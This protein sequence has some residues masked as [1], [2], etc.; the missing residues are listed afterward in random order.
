MIS[1]T[2]CQTR[3]SNW[4]WSSLKVIVPVLIL[5]GP[6]GKM[7]V[8]PYN[9]NWCGSTV[10]Q[11]CSQQGFRLQNSW[12]MNALHLT[13]VGQWGPFTMGIG[14][15]HP[16]TTWNRAY[17]YIEVPLTSLKTELLR[18]E[19][20]SQIPWSIFRIRVGHLSDWSYRYIIQVFLQ[21]YFLKRAKP[22]GKTRPKDRWIQG[23]KPVKLQNRHL[24]WEETLCRL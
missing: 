6:T 14:Q 12:P 21:V 4:T 24:S 8:A 13:R 2:I 17:G 16:F 11:Y 7:T 15:V 3:V 9:T 5:T 19:A 20:R 23:S 22:L 10:L 18:H 1:H